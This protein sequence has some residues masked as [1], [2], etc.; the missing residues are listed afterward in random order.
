MDGRMSTIDHMHIRVQ[1]MSGDEAGSFA[2]SLAEQLA[3]RLEQFPSA[4][5]REHI[6]IRLQV[7]EGESAT[8][9][10]ENVLGQIL[11]EL[12]AI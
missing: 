2:N 3:H 5:N 8:V 7:K 6:A 4:V 9:L 1:G 12:K 11:L 10:L